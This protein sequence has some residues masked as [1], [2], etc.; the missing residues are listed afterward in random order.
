MTNHEARF[1]G[2]RR[3]FGADGG[4][5]LRRAHVCVIGVGGVGSWAVEA[6]ARTGIGALT[7]VD[8]DDVCISNVNRQL[9]AVTGEFGKPK[10]EV[11]AARVKLINPDC[12]V[13]SEQMLFT[14]KTAEKILTTKYD[15][16]LDAI[17]SRPTKALLIA[18][19]CEKKIPIVTTGGAGGRRDPTAIRTNDLARTT[20]DG[21]LANLRQLLRAE[22]GFPRD[23][24]KNFGVPCVYSPEAQ[25]FPASDGSV[26]EEREP[27]S[28]LRLDCRT[29]YGT[30]T[31]VTGAFGFAAAAAAVKILTQP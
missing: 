6:L 23:A 16:V 5:R 20:H 8:L 15:C 22:Y 14:A 4:E 30:A 18:R 13:H 12:A 21:L 11:M 24:K 1:G 7:L 29:G 2:I 25:V 27:G 10:V 19:C 3:L 28:T 26:C 17:D 31:F 9:H